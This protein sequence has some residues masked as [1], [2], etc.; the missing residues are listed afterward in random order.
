MK[1]SSFTSD[2]PLIGVQQL[3]E[4]LLIEW[5]WTPSKEDTAEGSDKIHNMCLSCGA[6]NVDEKF[7]KC[8]EKQVA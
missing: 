4:G 6:V 2:K 5:A 7:H 1:K 3:N 8:N